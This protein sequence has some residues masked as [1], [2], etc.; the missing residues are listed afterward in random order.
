MRVLITNCALRDKS[1]TEVVTSE[2]AR[3]LAARGHRVAVFAPVLGRLADALRQDGIVVTDRI[4]DVPWTPD[5][6]HGHHNMVLAAALARF[7][8]VPSLFVCHSSTH[9]FD[10]APLLR[11]IGRFLAV[12]EA[13]RARIR[14]ETAGLGATIDLLPNAVDLQAFKP[15]RPL[16]ARPARGL[17]LT[18]NTGHVDAVREAAGRSGLALDELGWPLGRIVDDLHARLGDYD[19]V[20]ATARMALEAM[21]VGCAVVVVDGRGLAGLATSPVVDQWR[22]YNFGLRLLTRP[23]TVDAL[24]A[25]IARYDPQ[26]A[27][28][29]SGRIRETAPLSGYLDQVEAIH[30]EVA[31]AGY[32]C[33][34]ER[35]GRELSAFLAAWMRRLSDTIVPEYVDSITAERDA[36]VSAAETMRAQAASLATQAASL[37]EQLTLLERTA[38]ERRLLIEKLLQVVEDQRLRHLVNPFRLLNRIRARR[39]RTCVPDRRSSGGGDGASG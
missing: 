27:A 21:A 30:R 19:V 18:K 37:A 25:E 33:E 17:L 2:L 4:E 34:P 32:A 12:D 22:A 24:L 13:C 14:S 3:G 8:A 7:A 39:R 23:P 6:I 36:L 28:R 35:D 9:W 29:V 31:G 16:P 5:I 1:G 26:D 38:E 10:G 15:R 11:R 20:F